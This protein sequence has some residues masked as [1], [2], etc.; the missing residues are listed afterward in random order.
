VSSTIKLLSAKL[1]SSFRRGGLVGVLKRSV[2]EVEEIRFDRKFGINTRGTLAE[3]AIPA[4]YDRN[5]YESY[6]PTKIRTLREIFR[7]LP[8]SFENFIFLDF[9]SGKGRTLLVASE[10]PFRR[11][12]GVEFSPELHSIAKKNIRAYRSATQKCSVIESYCCNATLY[13]IPS[14]N[15]VL[16]LFNP[17]KGPIVS[18]ILTNLRESL[19]S[20]PRQIYLIYYNPVFHKLI[21][22]CHL[23][24]IVRVTK[25]CSIYKNRTLVSGNPMPTIDDST[26]KGISETRYASR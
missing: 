17:F 4:G 3:C 10:F 25:S 2:M 13:P 20:H 18:Q 5:L 19:R 15:T 14:E 26:D 22:D 11:I 23:L 16:F 12:I 21:I 6:S 7:E 9:G 8:V 1:L 24:E